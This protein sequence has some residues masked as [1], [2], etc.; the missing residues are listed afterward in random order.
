MERTP[1]APLLYYIVSIV[2]SLGLVAV[3]G[4]LVVDP[5]SYGIPDLPV[6]LPSILALIVYELLV[7]PWLFKTKI[8]YG[9]I[10]T[11]IIPLLA[12]TL[13][14][15]VKLQPLLLLL[16]AIT[17]FIETKILLDIAAMQRKVLYSL[18]GIFR[19]L[20]GFMAIIYSVSIIQPTL[21]NSIITVTQ[22][23]LA[24]L[25][26]II[27]GAYMGVTIHLLT[28]T[29][30]PLKLGAVLAPITLLTVLLTIMTYIYTQPALTNPS[31]ALETYGNMA[32]I[33]SL[34]APITVTAQVLLEKR[35]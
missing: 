35:L 26:F 11:P 12:L 22:L 34:L 19:G 3:S 7:L 24:L 1:N 8:L 31:L 23:I 9:A 29:R 16:G 18:A 33:I 21:E 20:A 10:R 27:L 4:R 13:V 28:M 2:G 25:P 32:R 15:G 14:Y 5:A 17:L 30:D 6:I